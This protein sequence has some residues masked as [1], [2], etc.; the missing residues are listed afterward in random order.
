MTCG[1]FLL[2]SHN[3]MVTALGSL[4]KHQKHNTIL[5]LRYSTCLDSSLQHSKGVTLEGGGRL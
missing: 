4:K 1:G 2:G 5:G 3:F